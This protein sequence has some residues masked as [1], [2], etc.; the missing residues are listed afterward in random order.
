MIP[1]E[2]ENFINSEVPINRLIPIDVD[3]DILILPNFI[4][5][6][7]NTVLVIDNGIDTLESISK[8]LDAYS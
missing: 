4:T 7:V 1:D 5:R 6:K 3:D 8:V 2:Y